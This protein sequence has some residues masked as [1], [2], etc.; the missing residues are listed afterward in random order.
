MAI[1]IKK[2]CQNGNQYFYYSNGKIKTITKDGQIKWK[3][4]Y[5]FRRKKK[6]NKSFP[7]GGKK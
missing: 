2:T 7:K 5:V 3:T 4:K 1:I 6:K